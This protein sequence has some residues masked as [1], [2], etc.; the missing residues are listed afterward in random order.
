MK[1]LLVTGASGFLGAHICQQAKQTWNVGGTYYERAIANPDIALFKVDLTDFTALKQLFADFQ[2][3]AVIHTAAQSKPN[4]CQEHPDA[5]YA[6]NVTAS[7][8]IAR[9]CSDRAI[10]CVFTS[11]DLV[12]DG[13]NPPYCESDRVSPIS[14]YGEQKVLAERGML[15]CHPQTAI[16]RMPLMFGAANGTASS[17]IQPFIKIL[18]EGKELKLFT[19]EVRTPVSGSTAANGLLLALEKKV[20]GLLHLGGKESISRYQFGLLMAEVWQLPTEN[21]KPCLQKD[22]PMSAPRS[23]NVSLNSDRAFALGYQPR[24]L[25][26]QLQDLTI[27]LS[28]D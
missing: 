6:I 19:D 23:P 3:E 24:S 9:L 18:K 27:I 12:F 11:T 7:L 28:G 17:F 21:I 1:K 15:E 5:S 2:P 26:E 25:Q 4:F 14:Y 22:V 10:P 8:N 13:L 20:E 16:C